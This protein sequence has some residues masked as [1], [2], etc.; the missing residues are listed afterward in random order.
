MAAQSANFSKFALTPPQYAD[1]W[2]PARVSGVRSGI[3]RSPGAHVMF[4][5]GRGNP[6]G[7]YKRPKDRIYLG[8]SSDWQMRRVCGYAANARF[9][10][11]GG[12]ESNQMP[13]R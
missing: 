9:G 13:P 11:K 1:Q 7:P 6:N 12:I 5:G 8:Y 4:S 3:L 2:R 10:T